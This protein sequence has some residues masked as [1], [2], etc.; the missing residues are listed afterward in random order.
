MIHESS[1][2][3][4][5]IVTQDTLHG[6]TKSRNRLL[7]PDIVLP[8]GRH[9]VSIQHL[10]KLLEV[11][12]KSVHKLCY[13]DVFPV[14][15]MNVASFSKIVHE[16]VLKA[17]L[18]KIPDCEAT[19]QYLRIF[20]DYRDSFMCLDMEPLKRVLL[21]YRTVYFLRIWK[22]FVKG[23]PTYTLGNNFISSNLYSCVE[24][25][26]KALIQLIKKFRDENRGM[27]FLP[28]LF[29]SECLVNFDRWER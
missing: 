13:T 2:V 19:V 3:H 10:R 12:S 9:R 28:I 15:R 26:A 29:D 24:L 18:D 17:L 6:C 7:K 22:E 11:E 21:M 25:N 23:A 14:D 20:R 27:D 4:G 16:N 1:L 5:N 8:M